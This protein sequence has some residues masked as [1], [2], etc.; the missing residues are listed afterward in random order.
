VTKRDRISLGLVYSRYVQ[1]YFTENVIKAEVLK[2]KI[3]NL[4][5]FI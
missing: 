5:S 4:P 1:K 3:F 2:N